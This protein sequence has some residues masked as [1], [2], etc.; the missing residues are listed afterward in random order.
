M[1]LQELDMIE[2][3]SHTHKLPWFKEEWIWVMCSDADEPGGCHTRWSKSEQ[4]LH[5]IAYTWNLESELKCIYDEPRCRAGTEADVESGLGDAVRGGEAG[6]DWAP[7]TH[8]TTCQTA[9]GAAAR[10]ELTGRSGATWGAEGGL[11]GGGGRADTWFT[12]HRKTVQFKKLPRLKLG[13]KLYRCICDSL[14]EYC[15][16]L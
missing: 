13:W 15:H 11:E 10:H 14:D 8:P 3:L 2:R 12:Q 16:N 7:Q 1:G 5:I 9:A 4:A 6:M